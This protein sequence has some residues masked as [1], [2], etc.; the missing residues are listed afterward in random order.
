MTLL[1]L[2]AFEDMLRRYP[3]GFYSRDGRLKAD[4]ARSHLAGKEM[5]VGRFYSER[6][7]YS[8]ALRR[9]EKAVR[10]YQTSNQTPEA[11]YGM[12]EAYLALGLIEEDQPDLWPFTTSPTLLD[13]GVAGT[14]RGSGARA[15][16]HVPARHRNRLRSV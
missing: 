5:A 1:A 2:N 6:G 7:H 15:T 10:D 8:A 3:D 13:R 16:R 9:F 11:L 14:G 4:L 12:V